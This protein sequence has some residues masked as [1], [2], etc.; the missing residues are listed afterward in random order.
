MNISSAISLKV[1][2]PCSLMIYF[3]GNLR[4][5][6]SWRIKMIQNK[7]HIASLR[8]KSPTMQQTIILGRPKYGP[9]THDP[10]QFFMLPTEISVIS[11]FGHRSILFTYIFPVHYY[12]R[13]YIQIIIWKLLH[14]WLLEIHAPVEITL[15]IG[16][17][18]C[19]WYVMPQF[20]KLHYHLYSVAKFK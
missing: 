6:S 11:V 15:C 4:S 16:T 8:V 1:G 5:F 9:C 10:N 13:T 18:W 3:K 19:K 7:K 17:V 20:F 12:A 14:S 2:Q